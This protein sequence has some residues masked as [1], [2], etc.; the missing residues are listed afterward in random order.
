MILGQL[1]PVQ[2]LTSDATATLNVPASDFSGVF[3]FQ[4]DSNEFLNETTSTDLKFHCNSGNLVEVNFGDAVVPASDIVS[5]GLNQQTAKP[6][7]QDIANWC[8]SLVLGTGAA[9]LLDNEEELVADILGK[10]AQLFS[11]MKALLALYGGT[12]AAPRNND[13]DASSVDSTTSE[14]NNYARQVL[15]SGIANNATEMVNRINSEINLRG[16]ASRPVNDFM[17][18]NP[19]QGD[20]MVCYAFYGSNN[21]LHLGSQSGG[22]I[23]P[24]F[25]GNYLTSLASA[26]S[27]FTNSSAPHQEYSDGITGQAKAWH[28][29][30]VTLNFI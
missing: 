29:Y 16:A 30:K 2:S 20:S 7:K 12:A 23:S 24:Q 13:P 10:D 9:D 26:S 21:P 5:V 27:L 14:N 18:I 15:L 11:S 3:W 17:P 8:T 28:G 19:R 6:I 22:Q 25:E 4:T 1:S